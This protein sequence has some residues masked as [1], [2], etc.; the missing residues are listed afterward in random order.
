MLTRRSHLSS[1]YVNEDE[2][3]LYKVEIPFKLIGLVSTIKRVL[4]GDI[5]PAP[6]PSAS[7]I[8]DLSPY[9]PI[10]DNDVEGDDEEPDDD[11]DDE[12]DEEDIELRYRF[13]HLLYAGSIA[14]I[15]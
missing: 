11:A 2:Q 7:K 14:L 5:V 15:P 4:P 1:L 3:V 13:V 10:N 8:S 9:E 6:D 12:P